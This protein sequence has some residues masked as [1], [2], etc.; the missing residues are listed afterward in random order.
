MKSI[1]SLVKSLGAKL[2][3]TGDEGTAITR[4]T[5]E[6]YDM[7]ALRSLLLD[8]AARLKADK[9]FTTNQV[10]ETGVPSG[11][12]SRVE[13]KNGESS[14]PLRVTSYSAGDIFPHVEEKNANGSGTRDE[15]NNAGGSGTRVTYINAEDIF[16]RV[17]DKSAESNGP[18]VDKISAEGSGP[19]VDEKSVEGSGS[20]VE[21]KRGERN[22]PRDEGNNA[23]GSPG[24]MKYNAERTGTSVEEKSDKDPYIMS[25]LDPYS[26]KDDPKMDCTELPSANQKEKICSYDPNSDD[27]I[28]KVL[29]KDNGL[30]ESDIVHAVKHVLEERA[31]YG[32]IDV[33]AN[34]GVYTITVASMKRRLVAVEPYPP[35]LER[36]AQSLRRSP[37]LLPYVTVVTNAVSNK[38]E[39]VQFLSRDRHPGATQIQSVG[40]TRASKTHHLVS[41]MSVRTVLTDDL[42][43]LIPFKQAVMKIDI[44]GAEANAIESATTLFDQIDISHVFFEWDDKWKNQEMA[45]RLISFFATRGYTVHAANISFQ[46]LDL[47]YEASKEWPFDIVWIKS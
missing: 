45:E 10:N 17:K 47:S 14:S 11:R 27:Y 29:H 23:E 19:H 39:T 46:Q 42:L 34:I 2:R 18:R 37:H 7:A 43:H 25:L 20:S 21:K 40:A 8:V 36:L 31:D 44:E 15:G 26:Y 41:D 3:G 38:Y 35:N 9:T 1:G 12:G 4:G 30:W 33:G 24:A 16:P 6:V 28:S 13:V 32:F 22:D 5:A